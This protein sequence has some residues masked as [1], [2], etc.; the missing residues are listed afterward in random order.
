M[1]LARDSDGY[2]FLYL[3]SKPQ[4]DGDIWTN[5]E[6]GSIYPIDKELFPDVKWEDSEPTEVEITI[7]RK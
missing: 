6:P 1:W 4:K 2:L 5:W 3:G 7:K